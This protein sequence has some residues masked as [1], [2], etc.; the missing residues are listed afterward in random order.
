MHQAQSTKPSGTSSLHDSSPATL[1]QSIPTIE[2][3]KPGQSSFVNDHSPLA[4]SLTFGAISCRSSSAVYPRY[5]FVPCGTAVKVG[6]LSLS[7]SGLLVPNPVWI[8]RPLY[9][10]GRPNDTVRTICHIEAMRFSNRFEFLSFAIGPPSWDVLTHAG[11]Q[12]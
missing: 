4:T 11:D 3:R 12:L 7:R 2:C 5:L 6:L 10:I 8:S 9:R 1:Q